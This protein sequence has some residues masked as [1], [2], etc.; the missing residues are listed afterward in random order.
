MYVFFEGFTVGELLELL[1]SSGEDVEHDVN[2]LQ[3]RVDSTF[4]LLGRNFATMSA[5]LLNS[6]PDPKAAVRRVG[7]RYDYTQERRRDM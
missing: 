4:L 5:I 6:L 3:S 7:S 2:I 1:H